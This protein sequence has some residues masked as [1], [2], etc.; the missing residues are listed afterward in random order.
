[1]GILDS[2][3]G[4]TIFIL[5]AIAALIAAALLEPRKVQL[6]SRLMPRLVLRSIVSLT[7]G[8]ALTLVYLRLGAQNTYAMLIS[9]QQLPPV[10][11]AEDALRAGGAR[12]L[13]V[14]F[15][16][17]AIAIAGIGWIYFAPAPWSRRGVY[18]TFDQYRRVT[19]R[20]ERLMSAIP[21]VITTPVVE[22]LLLRAVFPTVLFWITGNAWIG[23]GLSVIG[24]A[25]VYVPS[26]L[27]TALYFVSFGW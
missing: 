21:S 18:R 17:I 25:L 4:A 24:F 22:E 15:G 12:G 2:P 10:A 9:A 11:N 23:F 8:A 16:C 26:G 14:V 3:I 1:M 13:T 27:K 6:R 19:G 7:G 20:A 5:V